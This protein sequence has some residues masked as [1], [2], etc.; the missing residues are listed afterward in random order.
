MINTS[1]AYKKAIKKNRILYHKVEIA[2]ADGSTESADNLELFAFQ[3]SDGTSNTGSF[4]IGAAIA[5]QLTIKLNNVDGKF[6]KYD[7][8]E[9]VITA[10]VGL[11]LPDGKIEWLDKDTY[12]AEPGTIT[13]NTITVNAFD[14][15]TRFDKEYSASKLEYPTTLGQIVRDACSCCN[16]TLAPDTA[17]FENDNFI[18]QERPDDSVTFRQILQWVGQIACKYSR[19]NSKG[20]L[21]LQWYDVTALESD[22]T[23]NDNGVQTDQDGTINTNIAVVDKL[24]SG[25]SIETDDVVITGIKVT[26]EAEDAKENVYMSGTDGYVLS[27]EGN[28]LIQNGKGATVAS[29]L[30]GRL[31]GLKFR[32]L[33]VNTPGNPAIEA[34]DLGLVTDRKGKEYKTIF[35]NITYTANAAQN[36]M[37]GA[38]APTRRSSTRY[39]QATQVYKE[40]RKK[41]QKQKSDVEA[42]FENL[43]DAMKSIKGLYPI[44]EQQQDGSFIL[45][46]CDKPTLK[47]SQ[48]VIKMNA[49]GW[50]MST[51][52]GKTW[53]VGVLVDGTAITKILNAIGIKAEWINAGTIK[54]TDKDGNTTFLVD[55]DT[56]QVSINAN[57]IQ[58]GGEDFEKIAKKKAEAEVNNFISSVYS[59]DISSL[60]SQ[61]D[62]QIE[63]FFYDYEPTLQNIPASKWTATE[64]KKKHEGDLFYWKSKGYAY[65]FMQEGTTW[66]WQI[67]Q[68][69][70]ITKALGAAEKAQDTADGKRR[71]FLTTPQPPY[72]QG[73]MWAT[74]TTDGKAEIKICKTSRQSGS[75][76]S[77]D[78]ISPSYVDSNDVQEAIEDYDTSLGQPE[79]FNKLTNNGKTKSIRYK[80]GELYINATYIMSGVLAGNLINAK[81]LNVIDKNNQTTLKIDDDGNVYIK[82]AAFSLEGKNISDVV[83]SESDKFKT[84]NVILSNEYQG[85]PT[86]MNGKYTS[87]PSCSTTVKVLYGT[88]D[89]TNSSI[90]KWSASSGVSGNA[91]GASYTVTGLS[92]DT[93]T[94]TV[95]VT[96]GILSVEK[97][98]AIAKQ[99]QGIQGLQG[100][101]G[102]DGTNGINGTNG[103]NGK[104]TYFHI[105]YSSV[106]NPTSSSQMTEIPSTYIGTYVDFTEADS[107][108]PKKYVWSRFSGRD[109][110]AG[111]PGTNGADGKTTYLHIAYATSADG[112]TGFSVSDSTGK[113]Y[114]GQYTDFITADSTKP[115]SYKWSKIKGEDGKNGTN[116][117][118][119]KDGVSPTVSISKSGTTTTI[120]I[121]DKNG[122]HTQTVKDGTDG[123]PG[124]PGANGKTPYFHVKY[125]NDGGKTFTANSGETVGSYIGTCTDYNS[126]DPTSVGSY[127]WAKI[128]GET[129]AT[130]AT[131]AT[132]PTGATGA[133]G[134]AGPIGPTGATGAT[135]NGISS[136]TT[137]YLATSAGS[138][139]Y[140][141]T[142][143]WTTGVQTPT[144]SKPYLWSYQTTTYTNGTTSS[145]SPH[146]IGVR[147][148]DAGDLT[149]EQI[150]N[151]LTNNG[152]AQG[153]YKDPDSG[154]IYINGTYIK[155]K[156]I[157]ANSL[158]I[159]DLKALGAKIG[160][161]TIR[162]N[163][164][165]STNGDIKLYA[166][167]RIVIGNA[168]LA[169][170]SHAITAKYGFHIYCSTA[171]G[172]TDGTGDFKIYNLD[173]VTSG[174]HLVFAS[175][176]SS[177]A[178]L[179]SSSKRYKDHVS[180]MTIEEAEKILEIPVVWFKYKDGYLSEKDWLNG[181]QLPGFYAEDVY[182]I[183]PEAAQINEDGQVEDWN[184]R[185]MIPAMMKV[186]QN[187]NERIS[188]L[189]STINNL[190]ERLSKL[191][192]MI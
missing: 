58:I 128:K 65:R 91:S 165:Q 117:T 175:N 75:Y 185:V 174:G 179:S 66:K 1:D 31:N 181:K 116:G 112:K 189:E 55:M 70:D 17:S 155:S 36:L 29:F 180:D 107:T 159:S 160:G 56:G 156:S 149:Q 86:D 43:K 35:T 138:H 11:E 21:S 151:I 79:V 152:K 23:Q 24:S 111:I 89:V 173:H 171:T 150:F 14:Y 41:L 133:T 22:W 50:G 34:G 113:T 166:D 100:L 118:N 96:R 140:V 106:A 10:K 27:I 161:W 9:A 131:G 82:A 39:S 85:I 146:I 30:G 94:V 78:W 53:N 95:T 177:V 136:V 71:V 192:E 67:V 2:F 68:D 4:D 5:K 154:D 126:A 129:G 119:G 19:I 172:F 132:G 115:A 139:V 63:T 188:S 33:S 98:F 18:V 109:G 76:S 6:D 72:D 93:G 46:L 148:K 81:G 187:Q 97:I 122:T 162:S 57:S 12:I 153:L 26:E 44:S 108:D 191:G 40:L 3:I 164:L 51:D 64:E 135:G 143:G 145:T 144:A 157:A 84:L 125:S 87:F 163:Y 32:T 88:D 47:E 121:T 62:G 190:A 48:V 102:K 25:S 178:Y 141:S 7:F 114:I 59:N 110:S 45:Y 124:T 186:I 42:S 101:Q 170:N 20:K 176:G 99:K 183:F 77:T 134:P 28:K 73:D 142:S 52:G 137:Y 182:D 49:E 104:T 83:A 169:A 147:G 103:A 13:D 54:A 184:F 123:T 158:N 80:D 15:M 60:Q 92:T 8:S 130:G 74:S 90:I 105:K 16:V 37:C 69:T 168:T 127:T 38:E 167:G 120:T 61:I